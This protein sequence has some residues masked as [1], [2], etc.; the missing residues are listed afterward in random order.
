VFTSQTGPRITGTQGWNYN[1][2]VS[3]RQLY[4]AGWSNS[5]LLVDEAE[6]ARRLRLNRG[7]LTG[8]LRPESLPLEGRFGSYYAVLRAGEPAPTSF[9]PLY[10]NERYVLYR[11]ES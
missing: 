11:I 2:G 1:P 5:R 8:A 10:R 4:L 7:V 6:R 3:G 9:L